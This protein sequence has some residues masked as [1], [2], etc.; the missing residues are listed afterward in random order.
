MAS[1]E[2]QVP[3]ESLQEIQSQLGT[4]IGDIEALKDDSVLVESNLE[5]LDSDS[6]AVSEMLET[7]LEM[8]KYLDARLQKHTEYFLSLQGLLEKMIGVDRDLVRIVGEL[9]GR[10][11][12]GHSLHGGHEGLPPAGPREE[13]GRLGNDS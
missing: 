6:Q 11:G 3:L 9:R 12:E 13:E 7:Y 5:Q 2:D 4:I 1:I 10:L 8:F